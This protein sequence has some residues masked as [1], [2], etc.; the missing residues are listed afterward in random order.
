M[1]ADKTR[2]MI[3][4]AVMC[5]GIPII[6]VALCM[7]F[8]FFLR[9]FIS[10]FMPDY[11]VQGH[12]FDIIEDFGCRAADYVSIPEFFLVWFPP[13]VLSLATLVFAGTS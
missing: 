10:D 9:F 11:I 7:M 1:L 4:D 2:R 6:Y 12:R 3:V 13:M 8:M 5:W